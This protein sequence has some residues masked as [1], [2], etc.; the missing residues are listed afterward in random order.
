MTTF[1]TPISYYQSEQYHDAFDFDLASEINEDDHSIRPAQAKVLSYRKSK[2]NLVHNNSQSQVN[3]PPSP[4]ESMMMDL[5][6]QSDTIAD[7]MINGGD[8]S[9]TMVHRDSLPAHVR[10]TPEQKD[11]NKRRSQY[12]DDR[13]EVKEPAMTVRERITKE[14]IVLAEIRTNVIVSFVIE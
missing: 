6:Q 10:K 2:G 7:E 11:L 1:E 9:T 4:A 8:R 3:L 13:F 12:Y 14:S 5:P